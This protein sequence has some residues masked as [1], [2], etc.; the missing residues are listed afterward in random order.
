MNKVTVEL[1]SESTSLLGRGLT[2]G[3]VETIV[4][5]IAATSSLLLCVENVRVSC[6]S[7]SSSLELDT[8]GRFQ[9]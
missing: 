5:P 8:A 1:S 2:D 7:S 9:T 3:V 4:V 6:S